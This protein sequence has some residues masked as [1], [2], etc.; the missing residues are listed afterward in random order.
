MGEH[1]ERK[2]TRHCHCSGSEIYFTLQKAL[3]KK[4]QPPRHNKCYL[5]LLSADMLDRIMQHVPLEYPYS[6]CQYR[7]DHH[8]NYCFRE[9]DHGAGY[10]QCAS[11]P[12]QTP[13]CLLS[14]SILWENMKERLPMDCMW[15]H[16]AIRIA[17]KCMWDDYFIKAIYNIYPV[18]I[19]RD[20]KHEMLWYYPLWKAW[21]KFYDVCQAKK[22]KA[23]DDKNMVVQCLWRRRV[24]PF[25]KKAL[26]GACGTKISWCGKEWGDVTKD[27][28]NAIGLIDVICGVYGLEETNQVV[29]DLRKICHA[30]IVDTVR[31]REVIRS[32]RRRFK[33]E[34]KSTYSCLM[35]LNIG[36][37]SN[38]NSGAPVLRELE[39]I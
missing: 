13:R 7:H 36:G 23:S 29:G 20:I 14:I 16:V 27:F 10:Q 9:Q 38:G 25:S 5:G 31:Q 30:V 32:V 4:S 28:A 2:K 6:R 37:H 15:S 1:V 33:R 11:N 17:Q 22:G 18:L 21:L 8:H 24:H 39:N 3:H 34:S 19:V 12:L 35:D 26:Q